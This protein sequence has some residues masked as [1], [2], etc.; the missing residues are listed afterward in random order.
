MSLRRSE[1]PSSSCAVP[2]GIVSDSGGSKIVPSSIRADGSVRK[3]RKVRPGYTPQEDVQRFRP[4]GVLRQETGAQAPRSTT[5][6][7]L[8]GMVKEADNQRTANEKRSSQ[9]NSI[10]QARATSAEIAPSWRAKEPSRVSST[11]TKSDDCTS[12]AQRAMSKP[13]GDDQELSTQKPK[14]VWQLRRVQEQT[15]KSSKEKGKQKSQRAAIPAASQATEA[16][17]TNNNTPSAT[18]S[19][20]TA[21]RTTRAACEPA[22][23][24]KQVSAPREEPRLGAQSSPNDIQNGKETDKNREQKTEQDLDEDLALLHKDMDKLTIQKDTL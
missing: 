14:S 23:A 11:D 13:H 8:A 24:Q 22:S 12:S 5:S 1:A 9:R 10:G 6:R 2:S 20:P 21:K 15:A 7:G 18:A 3:E 19:T 16:N 17:T 4:R